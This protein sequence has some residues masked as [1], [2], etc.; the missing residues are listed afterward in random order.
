M[1]NLKETIIKTVC[2]SKAH[3]K[4]KHAGLWTPSFL[5]MKLTAACTAEKVKGTRYPTNGTTGTLIPDM[6]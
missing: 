6:G 2:E 5:I 4:N 1:E 3:C